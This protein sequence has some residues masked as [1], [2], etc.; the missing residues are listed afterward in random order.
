MIAASC[1]PTRRRWPDVAV[2]AAAATPKWVIQRYRLHEAAERLRAPKESAPALA[3]LAAA[4][5][6]ADQAHFA[7][8]FKRVVG[9]SPGA[10]ARVTRR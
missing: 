3:D 7:R 6:Y 2:T 4:L 10:F 8:D 5:G 1:S 9:E